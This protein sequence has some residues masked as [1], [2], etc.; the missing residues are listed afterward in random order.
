[1]GHRQADN[2][3]KAKKERARTRGKTIEFY[4]KARGNRISK[5]KFI[6]GK[7]K[8]KIK[9]K[10]LTV[11]T[12]LGLGLI[13]LSNTVFADIVSEVS[14]GGEIQNSKIGTGL[15]KLVNDLTG[16]LQWIIPFV[17]VGFILWH[18]FKIMTGDERDQEIHKKGIIKVLVCIVVGLIVV[19]IVN[20]MGRYFA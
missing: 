10:L 6:G 11:G 1:M 5:G 20:L 13:T 8:M 14:G 3:I 9:E 19:T 7:R 2:G 15:L 12:S 16:T 18:V 4:E 17:G